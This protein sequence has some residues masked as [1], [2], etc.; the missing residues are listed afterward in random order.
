MKS[1]TLAFVAA[2]TSVGL[3]SQAFAQA[4][5]STPRLEISTGY[6]YL[7]VTGDPGVSF[8][9]GV[10]VDLAVNAGPSAFVAE[11]GWSMR[12]EGADP[13]EVRFDFWHA[14]GGYRWTRRGHPRLWP[15]AQGLI[16][17][18]FHATGGELAGT[19]QTDTTAYFMVQPGGGVNFV[20]TDGLGILGAVDYRRIFL[21]E[22][23]DGASGLNEVRVFVGVRLSFR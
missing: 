17:A 16:G 3:T 21:D 2:C 14:A 23:A 5:A 18:A 9:F 19:D 8:P 12:S 6:Q 13:D 11:G 1:Y 10:A 7:F 15:Y 4:P 22:D 20:V